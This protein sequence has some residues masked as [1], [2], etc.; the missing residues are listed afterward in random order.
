MTLKRLLLAAVFALAVAPLSAAAQREIPQPPSPHPTPAPTPDNR[1]GA[2][3]R[4]RDIQGD[5]GR[6]DTPYIAPRSI[7][8]TVV[9]VNV[10][11]GYIVVAH[12]KKGL[13]TFHVNGKTKL[14]AEKGSPLG[15]KKRLTLEDFQEGQAVKVTYW[16]ED[17]RAF[18]V[19]A[20]RPKT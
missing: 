17:F 16:P 2:P 5:M 6:M 19:R 12:P 8:G 1:A 11:E 9:R 15:D 3:A 18:E 4:G 10:E 14:S 7:S 20:R 13:G